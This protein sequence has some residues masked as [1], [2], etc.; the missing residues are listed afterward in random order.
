M[1]CLCENKRGFID[2]L[3]RMEKIQILTFSSF[4]FAYEANTAELSNYLQYIHDISAI[5][6][7]HFALQ[8]CISALQSSA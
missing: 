7:A 5:G 6:G 1:E 2:S 4:E 8:N 3:F